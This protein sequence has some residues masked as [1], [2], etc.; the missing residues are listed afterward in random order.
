MR[1]HKANIAIQHCCRKGT[2]ELNEDAIILN[3]QQHI[4][5]VV[6]GA[7]SVTPYVNERGQTAA[8]LRPICSRLHFTTIS[9][10]ICP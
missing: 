5:G 8:I 10:H 4:Y 7:T 2:A 3:D 6:D 1:N 9:P